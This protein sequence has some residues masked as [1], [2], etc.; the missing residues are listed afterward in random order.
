MLVAGLVVC[1]YLSQ[2]LFRE[3]SQV[4]GSRRFCLMFWKYIIMLDIIYTITFILYVSL[5][6]KLLCD[7]EI[8]IIEVSSSN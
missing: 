3:I 8:N 1:V 5:T 2:W 4:L 6:L 7:I